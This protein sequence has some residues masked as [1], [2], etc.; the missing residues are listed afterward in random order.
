ME[1]RAGEALGA[2]KAEAAVTAAAPA[3][4]AAIL[5]MAGIADWIAEASSTSFL[6]LPTELE[7]TMN[8]TMIHFQHRQPEDKSVPVSK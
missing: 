3:A 5:D 4:A 6:A 8:E 2:T 7:T 1:A